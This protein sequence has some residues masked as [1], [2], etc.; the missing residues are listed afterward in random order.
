MKTRLFISLLALSITSTLFSQDIVLKTRLDSVSYA[1]GVSMFEGSKQF[2]M[3]LDYDM[4]AT[5]FLAAADSSAIMNPDEANNYL[6]WV[7]QHLVET[8]TK[9]NIEL[10]ENFL[11]ENMKAE[12][13]QVTQSGLQ[14][15]VIKQGEGTKPTL[16]DK[17]KV[18]Y[19]GYLLDGTIFDSSKD[20]GE[21]VVFDVNAVIDGWK[22]ALQLM[23]TGS[24][25]V[26]WVPSNLAYG[27][28]AMGE[29]IKP[30]STLMFE[31]E[32]LEVYKK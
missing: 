30:G 4:L 7:Y 16:A 9:K 22:E 24:E 18:D 23:S 28:R 10:G 32:L 15:I 11:K 6:R 26:I 3:N 31:M 29:D 17:V 19:V 13:V 8:N 25:F 5:S 2:N 14:Y 1:V 12:G 20:R 27:N 21:P